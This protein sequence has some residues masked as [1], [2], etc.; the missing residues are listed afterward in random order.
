MEKI[1][2]RICIIKLDG[3]GDVLR[4]TP[5]L[6]R[7]QDDDVTWIT[8]AASLCLLEN[9]HFIKTVVSVTRSL[10]I[11]DFVFDELYNFDE[12]KRACSLAMQIKAKKK[13]GYGL[14]DASYFPF[15]ADSAYARI[16]SC[17]S[18]GKELQSEVIESR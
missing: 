16:V 12:D 9:N 4:T 14:K 10:D 1:R 15:D 13:K 3:I 17:V 11:K 18:S 6:W 7:F 5:I 2:K 8:E